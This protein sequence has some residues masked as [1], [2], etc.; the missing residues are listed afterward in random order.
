MIDKLGKNWAKQADVL[1]ALSGLGMSK[2]DMARLAGAFKDIQLQDAS[3]A[4]GMMLELN[5]GRVTTEFL[6]M[7]EDNG[8]LTEELSAFLAA[9]GRLEDIKLEDLKK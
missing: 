4:F 1:E 5:G 6:Q 2:A 7:F 3:A 8:L 9:G